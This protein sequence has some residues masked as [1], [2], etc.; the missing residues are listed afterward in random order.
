MEHWFKRGL[1]GLLAVIA[2]LAALVLAR[3]WTL[4]ADQPPPARLSTVAFDGDAAVARLSRAIRFRTVSH[5]ERARID[6]APFRAFNAWL[7]EAYPRAHAVLE[8]ETV[9]EHALLFAWRGSDPGLAPLVLAAHSDVVPV[10]EESAWTNP[11]FG[12][13]VADGAVWG[14]GT[15]DDK[16]S[17][18]ALMEAVEALV[19]AGHRPART[20]YLA[21]GHDE[22]IGGRDGAARIAALLESRGIA[23][24]MVLDEGSWILD[25]VLPGKFPVA[26]I[27]VAEKGYVSLELAA[28]SAGGHS[29]VPPRL[30]AAGRVARAVHRVQ[31]E[32][33]PA[34]LIPT[35]EA[36]L[37]TIAPHMELAPRLLMSNLW[38]FEPLVIRRFEGSPKTNAA[39]RTTTAPTM[40]AGS[41]KDNVL[42][43]R[44]SAVVNFRILPGDS[45]GDVEARVRRIV[46]DEQVTVSRY[47]ALSAEPPPVSEVGSAG[48]RAVAAVARAL[49]ESV[50]AAPM[51]VVGTTDS[52]HYTEIAEN[53]YRFMPLRVTPDVIDGFHGRNERIRVADYLDMIRAYATLLEHAW[54]AGPGH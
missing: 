50:I 54:V 48:Y 16:G 27:A 29:S 8:R 52:R 22:E 21:F 51:L 11:P 33:F 32:P 10:D 19:G 12:G 31:S 24:A 20:V 38:L 44:A 49:D 39:V 46:N 23:P 35:G 18:V 53:V 13:V 37:E 5:T 45:V 9:G 40:L 30:T 7:A 1:A 2:A 36:L 42:P 43:E 15:L 3:A 26:G 17:L 25:G 28:S 4:E 34:R 14:R 41:T 6:S 47:G